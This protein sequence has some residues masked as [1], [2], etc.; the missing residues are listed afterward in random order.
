MSIP[1][2][3]YD[4]VFDAIQ[5]YLGYTS[6][7]TGSWVDGI[8]DRT[9]AALVYENESDSPPGGEPAPW[10]MVV[11]DTNLYGQQSLGNG[12]DVAGNR[13]DEDGTLWFHVMTPRGSGSREARRIGK[14]LANLFRGVRLLDDGLEFMDADMGA[15]DPGK[16]NGNF[17]LLSVSLD[18][19]RTD[20]Q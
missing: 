15:G 13:W 3:P 8:W 7:D 4:D 20:A 19:R 1:P 16:E 11:L 17:Y 9:I 18:W 6:L 2:P 5:A 14:A 12:I 10:V